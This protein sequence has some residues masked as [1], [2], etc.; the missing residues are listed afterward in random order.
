[1][2]DRY[3]GG[4]AQPCLATVALVDPCTGVPIVGATNAYAFNGLRA[5]SWEPIIEEAETATFRDSCGRIVC[6][7]RKN[8]DQLV[9]YNIEFEKCELPFELFT[10]LTGQPVVTDTGEAI[11]WY[12]SSEVDCQPRIALTLWEE[13]LSCNATVQYKKTVFP[14]VKFSFPT[15]GAENDLLVFNSLSARADRGSLAGYGDGPFND[16]EELGWDALDPAILGA[17]GEFVTDDTPPVAQCG[18]IPVI[19]DAI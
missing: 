2:A 14:F 16:D 1:M 10:L 9:G 8:C 6:E 11:G 15:P 7:H 17:I 3:C 19:A 18:L 4:Y 12:H 5:A 13:T